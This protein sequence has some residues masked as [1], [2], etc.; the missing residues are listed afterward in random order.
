MSCKYMIILRSRKALERLIFLVLSIGLVMM[1]RPAVA[2]Y[3]SAVKYSTGTTISP[4]SDSYRPSKNTKYAASVFTCTDNL[5]FCLGMGYGQGT[6]KAVIR[7]TVTDAT[8]STVTASNHTIT[9]RQMSQSLEIYPFVTAKQESSLFLDPF[10]MLNGSLT[11]YTSKQQDS[12]DTSVARPVYYTKQM[13]TF[14]YGVGFDLFLTRK[15]SIQ[16]GFSATDESFIVNG[17][18]K[19]ISTQFMIFSLGWTPQRSASF[20]NK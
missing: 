15:L 2:E 6:I 12:A 13:Y 8:G 10:V 16:A 17:A 18:P 4:E 11:R 20:R 3:R 19:K 14:E 7:D 5:L 1:A 9:Y